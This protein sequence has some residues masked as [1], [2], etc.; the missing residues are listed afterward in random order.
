MFLTAAGFGGLGGVGLWDSRR[1][2]AVRLPLSIGFP[3][4]IRLPVW[5]GLPVVG[6]VLWLWIG[7]GRISWFGGLS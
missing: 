2:L 1:V 4:W 5:R 6:W 7:P 3:L